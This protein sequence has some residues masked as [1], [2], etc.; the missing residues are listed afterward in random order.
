MKIEYNPAVD[1]CCAMLQFVHWDDIKGSVPGYNY[2]P[3]LD[4][5]YGEVNSGLSGVVKADL[6]YLIHDFIGLIFLPVDLA[7]NEKIID[8]ENLIQRLESADPKILTE[9]LFNTYLTGRSYADVSGDDDKILSAIRLADGTT[10]KNEAEKF[11]DY[12]RCPEAYRSRLADTMRNFLEVA[13]VPFSEIVKD[14][15]SRQIK[16]DQVVLDSEPDRFFSGY[17]RTKPEDGLET[18]Q[19]LISFFDELDIIYIDNPSTIIYGRCRFLLEDSGSIP[20]DQIYSLLADE[21]RRTILQMLCRKPWFI[22]EIADELNITSATVS[23]HMSKLSALDLVS[24]EQGERKRIYY[25][26]NRDNV[27]KMLEMLKRDITGV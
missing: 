24:Y 11:L 9:R 26:A 22:R 27:D 2:S 14:E 21:S 3:E 15:I 6:N 7:L 16:A 10:R 25:R 12:T 20:L 19:L 18:G 5:W 23:Y 13:F 8:P 1:L 17:C 4:A